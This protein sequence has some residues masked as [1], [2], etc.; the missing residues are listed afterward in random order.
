MNILIT[1]VYMIIFVKNRSRNL[2]TLMISDVIQ[3]TVSIIVV[4]ITV[5]VL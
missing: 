4:I 5:L 2:M 1:P 3:T